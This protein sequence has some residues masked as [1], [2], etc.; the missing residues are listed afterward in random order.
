MG[1]ERNGKLLSI[2]VDEGQKVTTGTILAS[3]DR[4]SLEVQKQQLL[5]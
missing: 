1:F 4:S 3:L 5:A 2:N